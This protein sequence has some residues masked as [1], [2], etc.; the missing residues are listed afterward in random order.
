M[1]DVAP[2]KPRAAAQRERLLDAAAEVF[3]EHGFGI[4]TV[5]I[6]AAR[7]K[8]SKKTLY[9]YF[10]RKEDIFVAAVERLCQRTLQPLHELEINDNDPER[11]LVAFGTRLLAQVLTPEAI[12]IHRV[13]ISEATRFPELSRLVDERRTLAMHR[14]RSSS[15]AISSGVATTN[16][17]SVSGNLR[18]ERPR[19]MPCRLASAEKRSKVE[20]RSQVSQRYRQPTAGNRLGWSSHRSRKTARRKLSIPSIRRWFRGLSVSLKFL[21]W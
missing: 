5:D 2:P 1:S 18:G 4:A 11:L 12:A 7:A 21:V 10:H 17:T 20:G 9:S 19:W 16:T 6:I 13:A 15:N 8:A 3:L 14:V